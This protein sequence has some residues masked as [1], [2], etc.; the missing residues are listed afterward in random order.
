MNNSCIVAP[1]HVGRHLDRG[2]AFVRSYNEHFDDDHLFIVFSNE[3][4]KNA[5]EEKASDLI[6]RPVVCTE[7][8]IEQRKPITQKKIFGARWVFDNTDFDYL[9]MID[10][11]SVFTDYKNYDELFKNVVSKNTFRVSK[12]MN[13]GV[14]ELVGK[15][16]ASRF[17]ND[18]DYQ[19]ISFATD[20]FTYYTWFN[21]IPIYDRARFY[22]FLSYINYNN[23][24]DKLEYTNFDY[25]MFFYYLIVKDDCKIEKISVDGTEA[26]TIKSGSFAEAPQDFSESFYKNALKKY[27]PMW[28]RKLPS[29]WEPLQEDEMKN[30]FILLHTDR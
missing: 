16:T 25:I 24:V 8:L 4:E 21:E 7:K 3:E 22:N 30:I 28:V 12:V 11:D 15:A 29:D 23:I 18:L 14:N 19:K 26:P 10:V 2:L 13:H 6:Y 5:F 27:K 20:N 17:F 9:A 1:I